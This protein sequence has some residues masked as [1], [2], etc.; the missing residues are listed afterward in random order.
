MEYVGMKVLRY[1]DIEFIG[2]EYIMNID[3]DLWN[4]IL[5]VAPKKELEGIL[6]EQIRFENFE[7]AAEVK[8]AILDRFKNSL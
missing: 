1:G 3:N 2:E 4:K 5:S 6:N 8:S 7:S